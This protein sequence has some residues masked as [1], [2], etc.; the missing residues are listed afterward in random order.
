[1]L[2]AATAV[3]AALRA[4]Q[5]PQTSAAADVSVLAVPKFAIADSPIQLSGDVRPR[6][7]V[8]V[9]GRRVAWLG[10]ESGETEIWIHPLKVAQDFHLEFRV[11]QY[12]EPIAAA[13]VARTVHV[14]P[15]MTTI[16]HAHQSFTVRQHVLAA[17]DDAIVLVLLDVDATVP[18]EVNVAF[19]SVLQ[20]A[21]PGGLGGQYASWDASRR[22]F[23]LSESRRQHN[24]YI[25][26][27]WASAASSQPAHALPDAPSVFT[28]RV[29]AE[30]ARR[31]FVPIA[32][33][34]GIEPRDAVQSK[35]AA[36]FGRARELYQ[37]RVAHAAALRDRG[38]S[39]STPSRTIDL[40]LEWAKVNLDEQ[41]VCNPDLGC[42]LVAG[43]GPSGRSARPGFGWFFGGDA[44]INSL[45][46][47]SAGMGDLV[48]Q[49]LRFLAKYQREDGKITHEISQAAGRIPWFTDFPYAYY[50]ADTTPFWIVAVWQHVRATGDVA[51]LKELWPAVRKAY[52][53]CVPHD[54]DGDGIIENTTAGLGAIEVGDIGRDLHQDIYLAAVWTRALAAMRELGP[55]AGDPETGRDATA[56][57]ARASASLNDR[58]W[59]EQ[60]GHHAF[61]ILKSGGTNDALTVW[62]STAAAFGL[63]SR[64][65]GARTMSAIASPRLTTDWGA[66]MLANDHRL[67]DPAHYNM[68]AVWPFVTGFAALG[69]Y[70]YDQPWAGF[71]LV[72]ALA[73]LAFDFARGRHPEL[74]SGDLYRPLDE[75]V[76]QQ[77]FA[78]SMFVTPLLRGLIGWDADA[79]AKRARLA[80]ALP[81]AWPGVEVRRLRVGTTLVD[82]VLSQS[83]QALSIALRADG[84]PVDVVLAPLLPHGA[85]DVRVDTGSGNEQRPKSGDASKRV[86]ITIRLDGRPLS[87]RFTWKGGLSVAPS[88][89]TRSP[90]DRSHGLRITDF[91]W[92][93]AKSLWMLDVAG[94]PGSR[95]EVSL[96]GVNVQVSSGPATVAKRDGDR[97]A[98][99]VTLPDGAGAVAVGGITL[100]PAAGN[101]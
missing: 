14:R 81:P 19:R 69:H 82:A 54:S 100:A 17:L 68:G 55:L 73:A 46:M 4:S 40:A 80:P 31:E 93:A 28:I 57:H 65:R 92:N 30:R 83:P 10:S 77:F 88:T 23:L 61:G 86:E 50:H 18:L 1:L 60:A 66:R 56:R 12:V 79:P 21:W 90:G 91:R 67:Y 101:R 6:Q 7:F 44:A 22:A 29:D 43:W 27:P 41:L 63:L 8:G 20:Y 2:S 32:I 52:A 16:V 98:L 74:L 59:I 64:D 35:Y 45:A 38:V 53:W 24:V 39:L 62:P 5:E 94:E 96:R 85:T 87:V 13:S 26:S 75:A 58:Y 3:S 99:A 25:G 84:P 72:D 51:L 49:G 78:T 47:S 36:V 76:P 33:V 34:G 11:P 48:A 70:N 9:E 42:G 15:E 37:A 95:H 97:M 71:P 89:S